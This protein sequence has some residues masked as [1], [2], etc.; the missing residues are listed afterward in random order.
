MTGLIFIIHARNLLN[1]YTEASMRRVHQQPPDGWGLDTPDMS[2]REHTPD[3]SSREHHKT[4]LNLRCARIIIIIIIIIIMIL[5]FFV[6]VTA[7]KKLANTA[8]G[9]VQTEVN[10]KGHVSVRKTTNAGIR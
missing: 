5:G 7:V 4:L 1:E 2:S 6:D 8:D 9:I 3:M 10:T